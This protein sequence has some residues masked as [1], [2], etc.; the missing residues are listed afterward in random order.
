MSFFR[1]ACRF[2]LFAAA[3]LA[4]GGLPRAVQAAQPSGADSRVGVPPASIGGDSG[5][6][7]L[8]IREAAAVQGDMVRLGDIAD[9]L[10]G[11]SRA[12]WEEL[13]ARPLW[14]AP[15][16]PGKPLQINRQRLEAAL[17][18]SLG[19]LAASCILPS[20]L[21]VQ[22]GGAAYL[23]PDLR[24]L[25]VRALTPQIN[26]LGGHGELTDFRLPA[27]AFTAHE[28]Q[29]I[30]LE[31][32]VVT[33]GRVGL[34]FAVKE[35]DGSVKRRFTGSVFLNLWM[36]VP[37]AAVPLNRG[38]AVSPDRVTFRSENLA[39]IKGAVW[40]GRGG[41]WQ[42]K[43][44]IG[45]GEVILADDLSPLAAIH[46]GDRVT[47]LYRRGN[48]EMRTLAEALEEGSPGDTIAVRNISSKKQVYATVRD[49]N[50]VET[51]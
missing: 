3:L 47:L 23:E 5:V 40:D 31:R 45:V 48:V 39:Y 20:S 50:T 21:A 26:L 49:A 25:V 36:D 16:T 19:E 51:K 42:V 17:K 41:P 30:E 28:G 46:R 8:R 7:R 4:L 29:S 18:E 27:Y 44:A 2:A 13:A 22:R 12:S 24:A 43:R 32:G 14:P 9:P 11:L 6:W 10:G 38:D 1:V 15:P 34:R 33:P 35:L 37:C